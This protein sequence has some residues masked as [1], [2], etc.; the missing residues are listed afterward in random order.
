MKKTIILA[1]IL[2]GFLLFLAPNLSKVSAITLEELQL[3]IHQLYQII[4]QQ[5]S[6]LRLSQ[7]SY[8]FTT[9]LSYGMTSPEVKNLQIVLGVQPNTGYF[10]NLTLATVKKFQKEHNIKVTGEVDPQ[11]R[12]VLNSLYCVSSPSQCGWCGQDCIRRTPTAD[13][14]QVMP[15]SEV[16]CK[17]VNGVCTKVPLVSP[18]KKI[19][20]VSPKGGATITSQSLPISWTLQ[21]FTGNEGKVRILFYG[22]GDATSTTGW[23]LVKDNL[24]LSSGSYTLDLTTVSI[25]DPSRCKLRI[26][27]YD[28]STNSWVTW[29]QGSYTGQ[30]YVDTSF[31]VQFTTS[32]S[33]TWCGQS[34]VRKTADMKCA[35]VMPPGGAECREINGT[36][37]IIYGTSSYLDSFTTQL[38][39]LSDLIQKLS[40]AVIQLG[41]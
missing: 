33:C 11:T 32:V 7:G 36:C 40:A 15:P 25:S 3:Q 24:P 20:I 39:Q 12:S 26:G 19:T 30:Y 41:R 10:G 4:L 18:S 17:E 8:C 28:P 16:E 14:P 1:L 23:Q 37:Q 29:S 31:S 35:Q 13:C 38:S 34:C 21:G 5:L 6:Q 27:V 22:G 2:T 9:D